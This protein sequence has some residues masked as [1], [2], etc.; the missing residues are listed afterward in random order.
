MV[1]KLPHPESA[2]LRQDLEL[3]GQLDE[4][5]KATEEWLG[6]WVQED[7]GVRW[8]RSLPGIGW[9]LSAVIVAEIDGIERFPTPQKMASYA[10][11][12]SSTYASRVG[13]GM[14]G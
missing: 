5:I 4:H 10:G 3:L 2:L 9:L 13:S 6:S 14:D 7:K 1:A 8:V 12:V 11:L